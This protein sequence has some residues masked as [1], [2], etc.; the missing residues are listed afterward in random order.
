MA[1]M[2]VSNDLPRSHHKKPASSHWRILVAILGWR[3]SARRADLCECRRSVHLVHFARNSVRSAS[4]ITIA[5]WRRSFL[6]SIENRRVSCVFKI[7]KYEFVLHRSG[8]LLAKFIAVCRWDQVR[9]SLARFAGIKQLPLCS[10]S[11][12][13][14]TRQHFMKAPTASSTFTFTFVGSK[15]FAALIRVTTVSTDLRSPGASRF[16]VGRV[17]MKHRSFFL[18]SMAIF[19]PATMPKYSNSG[20]LVCGSQADHQIPATHSKCRSPPNRF[21]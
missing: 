17:S 7:G 11:N 14:V 6:C 4:R 18:Y 16:F 9:Q 12:F 1:V 10:V 15:W 19:G 21:A 8:G 3:R 5:G 20:P 13:L 2:I